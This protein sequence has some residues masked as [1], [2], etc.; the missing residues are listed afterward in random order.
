MSDSLINRRLVIGDTG[1][2]VEALHKYLKTIGILSESYYSSPC[3][4][5]TTSLAVSALQKALSLEV[6]GIWDGNLV[7]IYTSRG[8]EIKFTSPVDRIDNEA[9][10]TTGQLSL[11][12]IGASVTALQN[13]LKDLGFLEKTSVETTFGILTKKAV[14]L[15]QKKLNVSETGIYTDALKASYE[16]KFGAPLPPVTEEDAKTIEIQKYLMYTKFLK[17]DEIGYGAK[18]TEAVAFLQRILD[19]Y[20]DDGI[21]EDEFKTRYEVEYAKYPYVDDLEYVQSYL[22]FV[23]LLASKEPNYGNNTKDAI[24]VIQKSLGFPETGL[25]DASYKNLYE[26]R[27]PKLYDYPVDAVITAI[28]TYLTEKKLLTVVESGFGQAT[29]EA[30]KK[31]QKALGIEE[32]GMW[33]TDLSTA[34]DKL[35]AS[36]G[37]ETGTEDDPFKDS[38]I[39][40]REDV[41]YN[42]LGPFSVDPIE[43]YIMNLNTGTV[44]DF[45]LESPESVSDSASAQFD[46]IS[47]RGRSSPIQ[48]YSGSGPRSISFDLNLSIDYCKNGLRKTVA[49]MRALCYP[50]RQTI[51]IPPKVMLKIGCFIKVVGIPTSVNVTW[52]KPYKEGVYSFA[53][54]SFS[55]EEVED[56]GSTASEVE[57]NYEF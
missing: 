19:I 37:E 9:Q 18:T 15:L 2:S 41:V 31:M 16:E 4:S 21:W 20:P 12:D 36:E 35:K 38:P 34:Y 14:I 17:E 24:K 56:V 3:Y 50:S 40:N 42:S 43:C 32:T 10:V 25:W 28:Q 5:N 51:I 45:S 47:P 11:G 13:Y 44:I 1:G 48:G 54:V 8:G 23:D 46:A 7:D 26:K 27:T 6:T 55:M 29:R 57:A 39:R 52:K 33:S 49:A 22:M 53:D 30:I